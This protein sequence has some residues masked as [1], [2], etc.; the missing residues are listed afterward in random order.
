MDSI[1]S[2][3]TESSQETEKSLRKFFEPTDKAKVIYTDNSLEFG[4]ACVELS[5]NH[6]TPNA[7]ETNGIAERAARRVK[8]VRPLYCGNQAWMKNGGLILYGMLPLLAKSSRPFGRWENTEKK[9]IWENHLNDQWFRLDLWC[10]IILF[11]RKTSEDTINL[12]S[13]FHLA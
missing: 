5:W 6:C 4:F 7:S 9:A 10:K 2:V 13:K 12:V 11:L 3:Q 8:E 1:L